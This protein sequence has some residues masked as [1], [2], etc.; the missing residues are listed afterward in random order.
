[1]LSE[2]VYKQSNV[3]TAEQRSMEDSKHEDLEYW[4][5]P[6]EMEDKTIKKF[7]GIHS[8][9]LQSKRPSLHPDPQRSGFKT[10]G[11]KDVL[12]DKHRQSFESDN[13]KQHTNAS[14]MLNEDHMEKKEIIPQGKRKNKKGKS[15]DRAT[16][17]FIRK[18]KEGQISPEHLSSSSDLEALCSLGEHVQPDIQLKQLNVEAGKGSP[19]LACNIGQESQPKLIHDPCYPSNSGLCGLGPSITHNAYVLQWLQQQTNQSESKQFGCNMH[20]TNAQGDSCHQAFR[21]TSTGHLCPTHSSPL[22]LAQ[23]SHSCTHTPPGKQDMTCELMNIIQ[24]GTLQT[25]SYLLQP[26]EDFQTM[27]CQKHQ[28]PITPDAQSFLAMLQHK[29]DIAATPCSHHSDITPPRKKGHGCI[30]AS[31]SSP[32]MNHFKHSLPHSG[33][34]CTINSP[35][36]TACLPTNHCPTC[37]QQ[38]SP[39]RSFN[40]NPQCSLEQAA[41][42]L[43]QSQLHHSPLNLNSGSLHVCHGSPYRQEALDHGVVYKSP[44][45]SSRHLEDT[46]MSTMS[47]LCNI[48]PEKRRVEEKQASTD[49]LPPIGVFWDIENCAVPRGKSALAVVQS[50][51]DKLFTGHREAEFLCVCDINKESATVIQELN[52]AQV[53]VAHINA[54]AKNAADD[55]LKQSLRRFADTHNPP[56]TV[57]L[58]SGDINF[59]RDLSDLRH[60][61]NLRVI[62]VHR[63]EASE[64][65]KA[66]ANQTI[67]YQDIVHELPF[68]SP[69]KT[70]SES[71]TLIVHNLPSRKDVSQLRNRLKQLSDNCGG[72]VL[73]MSYKNAVIQFPNAEKASRA[74]IRL[75]GEN[76]FG[77]KISVAYPK[78]KNQSHNLHTISPSR[79]NKNSPCH[80]DARQEEV[81][82]SSIEGEDEQVEDAW[83]QEQVRLSVSANVRSL[84]HLHVQQ[85]QENSHHLESDEDQ[86]AQKTSA[87]RIAAAFKP[88][89]PDQIH[90]IQTVN[91][92]EQSKTIVEIWPKNKLIDARDIGD[93]NC[94]RQTSPGGMPKWN[95]P[96]SLIFNQHTTSLSKGQQSKAESEITPGL[97]PFK[98]V[99]TVQRLPTPPPGQTIWNKGEHDRVSQSPSL[100]GVYRPPSPMLANPIGD[101]QYMANQDV[102]NGVRKGAELLI[103]NLDNKMSRKDLKHH[104]LAKL[105]DHC[106]VLHLIFG[107]AIPGRYQAVVRVPSIPDA[108]RAMAHINR[109]Q[110]GTRLLHVTLLLPSDSNA[111]KLRLMIIPM[112]QEIPGMCLP[113]CDVK[114]S[115]ERRYRQVLYV[116]DLY[117]IP[118]TLTIRDTPVGKVV[119]LTTHSRPNSPNSSGFSSPVGYQSPLPF[120]I[121][122]NLTVD[123][124]EELCSLHDQRESRDYRNLTQD[125]FVIV[126][127]KTFSA[128]VHSLLQIH[129]GKMPL[130]SFMEC[131]AAE[132]SALTESYDTG[133]P[134]E[135]LL[136][137]IQGVQVGLSQDGHK[138]VCWE[139]RKVE[140]DFPVGI[141]SAT[142]LLPPQLFQF[143]KEAVELLKHTPK[144][145]LPFSKFIPSYHHHFGRQCRVADYGFLKL[146]ELFEAISHALQ[147]LGMTENKLLTLTHRIQTKRFSQDLLKVLKSQASKQMTLQEFPSAYERCFNKPWNVIDYGVCD[148]HDL[149]A[150]VPENMAMISWNG[151]N[152]LVFI[153]KREQTKEELIRMR[154]FSMEIE[155]L[156]SYQPRFGMLFSK[157]IPAFHHHFGHQCRVG[158]YGFNK[159]IELLEALQDI[160]QVEEQGDERVVKLTR[161]EQLAL[162]AHRTSEMLQA[163]RLHLINVAVFHELYV[164]SYT[165]S[166]CFK[167][168]GVNNLEELM[169]L[170]PRVVEIV[171]DGA[172]KRLHL[173]EK[174]QLSQLAQQVLVVFLES[175]GGRLLINDI[176][177]AYQQVWHQQLLPMEYGHSRLLTLM[178]NLHYILKVKNEW[179]DDCY[180]EL[181]LVHEFAHKVRNVLIQNNRLSMTCQE[182][183]TKYQSLYGVQLE[184]T[185][186]GHT[187]LTSLIG[188]V[189]RVLSIV[190]KGARQAVTLNPSCLAPPGPT[191][192][193]DTN[194]LRRLSDQGV[195]IRKVDQHKPASLTIPTMD[196]QGKCLTISDKAVADRRSTLST[197]SDESKTPRL[198]TNKSR[199]RCQ[200]A[201]NFTAK[202]EV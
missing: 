28:V 92:D 21:A 63:D 131:F 121:H 176:T 72:K 136:T 47:P 1:M 2:Y 82:T 132:F 142:P 48:S 146:I 163:N 84:S 5:E 130:I 75:E 144:C 42:I 73:H 35:Q 22:H 23:S 124:C 64:A 134:L 173:V 50:I 194:K 45:T 96:S 152:T 112:L 12:S 78:N 153:P 105:S 49:S 100:R 118:D 53:T 197:P 158:D 128:Q 15:Q 101:W 162:L 76:V 38:T 44:A 11:Q 133:V 36:H 138:T 31:N 171:S 170:F 172:E 196:S 90:G 200:L 160:I 10:N 191:E 59:A 99:P 14:N 43:H 88:I 107:G 34:T 184:P 199:G 67:A 89:Q 97:L 70:V 116:N 185:D 54:T 113:L 165:Y 18:V 137:C 190:S 150:E 61:N 80:V 127:L 74:K 104:L 192:V 6:Y 108:I 55:K 188:T 175:T 180:I 71:N 13:V 168:L 149:L 129:H 37:V 33:Q 181:T 202:E 110:I 85:F 83:Q 154:K 46:L 69:A 56:A 91:A 65:L 9:Q 111:D 81:T 120:Y 17:R 79:V 140:E 155:E 166:I 109:Y 7:S 187:T 159:L 62:L 201:A 26:P 169:A 51:R 117:Q 39:M 179:M 195:F 98:P 151:E 148:I 161:N 122:R 4:C 16:Q 174:M 41:M 32:C 106:K 60:R 8:L 52:D 141:R 123:S 125:S 57:V 177:H 20:A 178:K 145:R 102:D 24:Q 77:S 27:P 186:Y 193:E 87:T 182:L 119:A 114:T 189:P 29:P 95:W 25:P 93:S 198:S 139:K 156:L 115:F 135:H 183:V 164:R 30:P 40:V 58:I 103:T 66:C 126:S 147:V 68:R 3:G 157:F 167:D 19:Y 143:S 86:L 94:S